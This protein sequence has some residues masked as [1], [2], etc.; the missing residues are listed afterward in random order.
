VDAA[1][2]VM[3]NKVIWLAVTLLL[4]AGLYGQMIPSSVD[5]IDAHVLNAE[6]IVIGTVT[7]VTPT[8]DGDA[9]MVVNVEETIKGTPAN[10]FRFRLQYGRYYQ[11]SADRVLFLVSKSTKPGNPDRTQSYRLTGNLGSVATADFT[12]IDDPGRLLQYVR[13]L[14]QKNAVTSIPTHR[15][16]FPEE[17]KSGDRFPNSKYMRSLVVPA[18]SRLENWA[19]D[20]VRSDTTELRQSGAEALRYFSSNTNSRLA[21]DL[22]ADPG[23]SISKPAENNKGIEVREYP[24]RKAAYETVK[25]WGETTILPVLSEDISRLSS[26]ELL[27]WP[28]VADDRELNRLLQTTRLKTLKFENK[29][30]SDSQLA[31]VGRIATLRELTVR[32]RITN[33]GLKQLRGLSQ[34]EVLDLSMSNITDDGL[35]ELASMPKLTRL[36]VMEMRITGEGLE[37]LASYPNLKSLNV[38]LTHITNDAIARIQKIRPDLQID[39]YFKVPEANGGGTRQEMLTNDALLGNASQVVTDLE[40]WRALP[41]EPD[42]GGSAALH[43]AASHN[44][45]E[46]VQILLDHRALID[47]RDAGSN[48]PLHW[49]SRKGYTDV[50]KLLLKRGANVNLVNED[51]NSALHFAS[52]FGEVGPLRLLLACGASTQIRNRDG[53]TPLDIAVKAGKIAARSELTSDAKRSCDEEL[54]VA[55]PGR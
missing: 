22:F 34:L 4:P 8:P 45:T 35:K 20:A 52:R 51:G 36:V 50:M 24:V 32:G 25:S 2:K 7:S 1:V 3:I 14:N 30:I 23:F 9:D 18:D 43:Y 10:P 26:V 39:L 12:I 15:V 6:T 41:N 17:W 16:P 5:T 11:K 21:H 13:Q 46:I 55:N 28:G 48:T 29:A 38:T 40:K 47:V 31:V 37:T 19:H 49:A 44:R 42:F 53:E 33:E 54:R 27:Q